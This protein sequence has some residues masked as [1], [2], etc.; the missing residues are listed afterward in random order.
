MKYVLQL[1]S[2]NFFQYSRE[3][4]TEVID[5]LY[6]RYG[7]GA[8]DILH[9]EFELGIEIINVAYQQRTEERLYYRWCMLHQGRVSFDDFKAELGINVSSTHKTNSNKNASEIME[10]VEKIVE[11]VHN[12]NI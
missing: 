11:A 6:S 5:L 8:N 12:G 7:A 3:I 9:M 4:S 2:C 10:N 1:T